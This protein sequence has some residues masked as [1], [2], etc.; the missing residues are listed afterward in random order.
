MLLN[1][2]PKCSYAN[3]LHIVFIYTKTQSRLEGID[4]VLLNFFVRNNPTIMNLLRISC[5][6][7]YKWL[8]KALRSTETLLGFFFLAL[9]ICE[10][11][12]GSLGLG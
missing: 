7:V 4:S 6:R 2:V 1:E 5:N 10:S 11:V 3:K 9:L 12:P 8:R